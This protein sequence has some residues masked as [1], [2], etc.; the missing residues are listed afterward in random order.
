MWVSGPRTRAWDKVTQSR[1]HE[2]SQILLSIEN[3]CSGTSDI[4]NFM[5][6]GEPTG[7]QHGTGG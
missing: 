1:N 3:L 4:T 5:H 6:S 2:T 7:L